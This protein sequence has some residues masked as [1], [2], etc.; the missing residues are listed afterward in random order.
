MVPCRY[1]SPLRTTGAVT[2]T[3]PVVPAN[4][5]CT[6]GATDSL[7]MTTT[8]VPL[9][10]GKCFDNTD[11]PTTESTVLRNAS[12]LVRPVACR[13]SAPNANAASTTAVPTQTR[14]GCRE[15]AVPTRDHTPVVVG[16]AEPSAGR[17][18][19]NT[20]RPQQTSNAGSSV[21][22]DNR[23]ISTPIAAT[24]PRPRVEFIS[25]NIR[26]SM[27]RMTVPAL[28]TIAG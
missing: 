13:S 8:G 9:P 21:I 26:Q 16:S 3:M 5:D 11:S 7:A 12:L 17:F 25:A 27:P 4:A 24:G 22:I 18:G 14:R 23:A 2:S 6:C 20:Q 15:I 28:A 1:A 19:Q 10:A